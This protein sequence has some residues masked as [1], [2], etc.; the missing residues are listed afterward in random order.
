MKRIPNSIFFEEVE[1]LIAQGENVTIVVRGTSMTPF[2]RNGRDR[3]VLTPFSDGDLVRGAVVLF[4][5]RGRHL[6]HRIVRHTGECFEIQGDAVLTTEKATLADVVAVVREVVREDGT[7]V[8]NGTAQWRRM[9]LCNLRKRQLRRLL[10][11]L[12]HNVLGK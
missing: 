9:W 12:K 11:H 5:Y 8:R 10:S 7:V 1:R 4:R 2:L 6:L 3:V